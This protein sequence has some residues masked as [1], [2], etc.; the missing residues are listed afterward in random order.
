[1]AKYVMRSSWSTALKKS[2]AATAVIGKIMDTI[3]MRKIAS[4]LKPSPG[5]PVL[6]LNMAKGI[7]KQLQS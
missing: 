3:G 2:P 4:A 7:V 5:K 6:F 1:M